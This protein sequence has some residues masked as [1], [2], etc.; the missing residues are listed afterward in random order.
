[1]RMSAKLNVFLGVRNL[2]VEL[3]PPHLAYLAQLLPP[4]AR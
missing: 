1:M 2:S 3:L 4:P